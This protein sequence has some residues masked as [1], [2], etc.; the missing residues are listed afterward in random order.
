[1]DW[2]KKMESVGKR[3]DFLEKA[4]KLTDP[5][6][7]KKLEN[8]ERDFLEKKEQKRLEE[9][10][11][12]NELHDESFEPFARC[13]RYF[14]VDLSRV[15]VNFFSGQIRFIFSMFTWAVFMII[16]LRQ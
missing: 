10:K 5:E 16:T 3:L 11:I 7:V 8:E 4:L 15:G 12:I 14:G 9:N 1:M 13:L 2:D 6:T